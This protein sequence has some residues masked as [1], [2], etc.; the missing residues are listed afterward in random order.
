MRGLRRKKWIM[1]KETKGYMKEKRWL[2]RKNGNNSRGVTVTVS[3]IHLLL[4]VSLIIRQIYGG[5][6]EQEIVAWSRGKVEVK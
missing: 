3:G 1:Q 2:W 5:Y 4:C 6:V